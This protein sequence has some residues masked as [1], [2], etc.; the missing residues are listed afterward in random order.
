[1]LEASPL[2]VPGGC[3]SMDGLREPYTGQKSDPWAHPGIELP[4]VTSATTGS[5]PCPQG[6]LWL[7]S[8]ATR[9]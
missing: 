3:G 1:M 8:S 7:S 6:I 4:G 9:S 2:W 5:H